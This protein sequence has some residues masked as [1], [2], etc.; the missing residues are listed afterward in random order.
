[1]PANPEDPHTYFFERFKEG[2]K[3]GKWDIRAGAGGAPKIK[4][5]TNRKF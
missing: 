1:M 3:I 2:K 4:I 5:S